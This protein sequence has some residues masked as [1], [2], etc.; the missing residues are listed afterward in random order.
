MRDTFHEDPAPQTDDER[1]GA[2]PGFARLAAEGRFTVPIAETFPLA[3]WRKALDISLTG[4]AHGK[5]LLLPAVAG[6]D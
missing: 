5:L 4:H 1:F 2:F 3:D 6:A